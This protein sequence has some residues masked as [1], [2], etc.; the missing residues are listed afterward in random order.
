[1]WPSNA[2]QSHSIRFTFQRFKL[3]LL[4]H[5]HAYSQDACAQ[6]DKAKSTV[7]KWKSV[8][9]TD[10][11]M[12]QTVISSVWWNSSDFFLFSKTLRIWF[13]NKIFIFSMKTSQRL[14]SHWGQDLQESPKWLL[15]RLK[16]K[17]VYFV[18][19]VRYDRVNK[20]KNFNDTASKSE[21]HHH[22]L[23][24]AARI[25]PFLPPRSLLSQM[26][27]SS[28]YGGARS[29]AQTQKGTELWDYSNV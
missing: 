21:V 26:W 7:T 1:M 12:L 15:A 11:V 4:M 27:P 2:Q 28:L 13:E 19:I 18:P 10:C 6:T 29:H 24:R 8:S 17:P 3:V 22:S 23:P 9:V 25:R 16:G 20:Q 14:M 5:A